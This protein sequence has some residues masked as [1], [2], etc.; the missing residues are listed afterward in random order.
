MARRGVTGRSEAHQF[1]SALKWFAAA[2][3]ALVPGLSIFTSYTPPFF[4]AS[5]IVA[6]LLGA[7]LIFAVYA[8]NPTVSLNPI[9]V[10]PL[11]AR[12]LC[13]TLIGTICLVAYFVCLNNWTVLD[14]QSF[15]ERFQIGF[16]TAGWGL[17]DVGQQWKRDEPEGPPELWMRREG[18]FNPHGPRKL[19]R[20]GAINIAGTLL[21]ALFLVSFVTWTLG[22]SLLAKHDS[23]SPRALG[24]SQGS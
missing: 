4:P 18:A 2:G 5:G 10:P 6:S 16:G 9:G 21:V 12:G 22:F 23:L 19:W 13:L 20:A 24:G 7:A 3:G 8:Y 17:T 14:P 15:E 1:K 11:V